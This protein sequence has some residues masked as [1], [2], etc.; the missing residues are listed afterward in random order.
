MEIMVNSFWKDKKVL[1][2]GDSGFKGSWLTCL[3]IKLQ[4]KI[5]G[6]SLPAIQSNILNHELNNDE[7][8][9]SHKKSNSYQHNDLDIREK[10]K[11]KQFISDIS[12]DF[13]FHLAAQP[14]VLESYKNPVETWETNVIGTI[15]LLEAIRNLN[16]CS[17]VIVTTDKVYENT[18][19]LLGF[20]E[21]D[22]LG[23]S[24]PY[25]SSKAAVELA[26]KSWRQSF[27]KENILI[28][29]ARAGN[30]IGG[31][32]WSVNRIVPDV[33]RTLISNGN[34]K[35]R[36]PYAVRP[37][38]HV[39]EP[40]FGYVILAETQYK[41]KITGS[42]NFGPLESQSKTVRVL[43][44]EIYKYWGKNCN[45]QLI[46]DKPYEASN[47]TLNIDKTTTELNWKPIWDFP[48]T[49]KTT[50]NWHKKFQN[51]ISAFSCINSD[52]EAYI[53]KINHQ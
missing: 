36:Y 43:I 18:N 5:Y 19:N 39:L 46:K 24:D 31:G 45:E 49:V 8:F 4:C 53:N 13:I 51:D 28:S 29:T 3:L 48:E 15:N 17:V 42:Y 27:F 52:I 30:V 44:D 25:S 6:I 35:I 1:I 9:Q 34:L 2:T 14:L 47:L 38:Q 10:E 50:I 20:K 40:L 41:N 21:N 12:P 33:I 23:G 32:D 16:K 7:Q 11:L 26:V 37:W 22:R